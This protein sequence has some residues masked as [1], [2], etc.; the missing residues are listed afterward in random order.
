MSLSKTASPTSAVTDAMAGA[1][2]ESPAS[3][4]AAQPAV[5]PTPPSL[6][7]PAAADLPLVQPAPAAPA[8]GAQLSPHLKR[9]IMEGTGEKCILNTTTNPG[10]GG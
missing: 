2:I 9:G 4:P 1:S 7:H 10:G 3:G 8:D 5:R 6:E